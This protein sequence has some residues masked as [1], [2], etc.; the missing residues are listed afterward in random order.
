MRS[1]ATRLAVAA[2]V[3]QRLAE[4]D[5]LHAALDQAARSA[6][7]GR[8]DAAHAVVNAPGPEAALRDLEARPGPAMTFDAGTRTFSNRTSPCPC[9]RVVLAE[10]RQHALDRHARGVERHQH[11]RVLAGGGRPSASVTPMK[12]ATLQLGWPEA[13]WS[14]T[15]WP[16]S[17]TSSPSTLGG[18]AHV[19]GVADEATSGSV[20][21]NAE[22][23]SPVEQRRRA[24]A[25]SAPRSRSAPEHLHVAG[26]GRAA[27]EDLGR[28]EAAAHLLGERRVLERGE[29]RTSLVG[30]KR[31][32]SP[33]A[34][35]F[36][37]SASKPGGTCHFFQSP[38]RPGSRFFAQASSSGAICSAMNLRMRCFS[39]SVRALGSKSM[40]R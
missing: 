1:S 9:G 6:A 18:G 22:R 40:P 16:L 38:W 37:L 29:A 23:I 15:C 12:M 24:T 4:G 8:A 27:V 30:R 25:P 2:Q 32:H 10:H 20:M 33:S 3:D 19:G 26:V 34:R 31:F 13:R 35:A 39:S 28:E 11:H 21:Q 5:A 7:L 14:T 36:A 17:T